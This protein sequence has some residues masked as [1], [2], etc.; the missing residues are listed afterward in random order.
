MAEWLRI[1][2]LVFQVL[3]SSRRFD[4]RLRALCTGCFHRVWQM[5]S[6]RVT[7]GICH[8]S[9]CAANRNCVSVHALKWSAARQEC[10][11]RFAD[12]Q[13]PHASNHEMTEKWNAAEKNR[14]AQI[15]KNPDFLIW[16]VW[17]ACKIR[18]EVKQGKSY[19]SAFTFLFANVHRTWFF[20]TCFF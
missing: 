20:E 4:S 5:T 2:S 18:L 13:D 7:A 3:T 15:P 12:Q 1:L 10:P 8:P 17:S 16:H 14:M 6:R 9:Q 19:W 11:N